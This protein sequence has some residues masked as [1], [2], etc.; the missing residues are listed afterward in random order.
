MSFH[1]SESPLS[2]LSLLSLKGMC[3]YTQVYFKDNILCEFQFRMTEFYLT[4]LTLHLYLFLHMLGTIRNDRISCHCLFALSHCLQ[5]QSNLRLCISNMPPTVWQL[6]IVKDLFVVLFFL[7]VDS[8]RVVLWLFWF[9]SH[10]TNT[11]LHI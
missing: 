11:R 10:T 9:C 7:S 2:R 4:S 8:T 3:L 1:L 6:K 5:M